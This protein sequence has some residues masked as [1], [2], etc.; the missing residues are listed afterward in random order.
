MVDLARPVVVCRRVRRR[1]PFSNFLLDLVPCSQVS[2]STTRVMEVADHEHVIS[3]NLSVI[4]TLACLADKI[5]RTVDEIG[6]VAHHLC[7]Q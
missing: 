3:S 5:Q 4:P 7:A 1:E 6:G 2:V